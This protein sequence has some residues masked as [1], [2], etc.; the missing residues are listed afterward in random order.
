[1]VSSVNKFKISLEAAKHV[2]DRVVKLLYQTVEAF[3]SNI[4]NR[5]RCSK[6]K[7]LE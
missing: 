3:E 7:A 1:M 6:I 4:E 5:T 2:N